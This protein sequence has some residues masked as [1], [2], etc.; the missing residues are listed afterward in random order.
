[1][2]KKVLKLLFV[3]TAFMLVFGTVNTLAA[4]SGVKKQI[5]SA[6]EPKGI[7]SVYKGQTLKLRALSDYS[8]TVSAKVDG[9][10]VTLKRTT[11]KEGSLYWFEGTYKFSA[12]YDGENLGAIEFTGKLNNQTETKRTAGLRGMKTPVNIEADSSGNNDTSLEAVSGAK[13]EVTKKYIDV[14]KTEDKGEDY[15]APYYY[16]LP[17]GTIDFIKST[18]D[19]TYELQSGR[20]VKKD[21]VRVVSNNAKVE[22]NVVSGVSVSTD[23]EMTYVEIKNDW[24]VPFNVEAQPFTYSSGNSVTAYKPDKVLITLDYTADIDVSRVRLPSGSAF[25]DIDWYTT[26]SGNVKQGVIELTLSEKGK[27]YGAYAEY[28]DGTL[29]LRFFNPIRRLS[30]ARI[31]IDPGHGN[32]GGKNKDSGAI[33]IDGSYESKLNLDKAMALRDELEAR[34]ATVYMLDTD[35]EDFK[36]LYKRCQTAYDWEPHIY[37][38]VHHNSG[39]ASARGVETYY[40]TPFSMPLAKNINTSIYQA[41]LMM[42]NSSGA[43]NRGYKFS[44]FAV[45]RQKQFASVLVEYGFVTNSQEMAIL[46]KPENVTTFAKYTADGITSYFAGN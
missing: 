5:L 25:S 24:N 16:N 33:G 32:N 18:N 21:D 12:V 9:K 39:S 10:T 7:T 41:Y 19:T 28:D 27:Y 3:F 34:G 35:K 31:V 29:T 43:K 42:E 36:D 23:D 13:V 40:N 30:D 44:E 14:F 2:F 11:E 15:A 1:M 46:K 26:K 20:K 38:S 37:I 6:I 22:E 45:T 8:A 17:E 4:N